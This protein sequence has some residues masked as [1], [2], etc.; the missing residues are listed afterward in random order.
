[1]LHGR[2]LE[3]PR[4]EAAHRLVEVGEGEVHEDESEEEVRH[5]ETREAQSREDVVADRMLPNRRVDANG[6]CERPRED[7]R[8]GGQCDSREYAVADQLPYWLLRRRRAA[9]VLEGAPPLALDQ[10]ADPPEVAQVHRL[11]QPKVLADLLGHPHSYIVAAC[12]QSVDVLAGGVPRRHLHDEEGEH[13]YDHGS[14]RGQDQASG[15]VCEQVSGSSRR[16]HSNSGAAT[17]P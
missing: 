6:D 12:H 9:E 3:I 10:V 13:G 4:E 2:V 17:P 5:R 15:Q 1:M 7:D 16:V 11:V 14:E 8:E